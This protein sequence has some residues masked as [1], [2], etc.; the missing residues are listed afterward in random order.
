MRRQLWNTLIAVAVA[1]TLACNT[2]KAPAEAA[3]KAAEDAVNAARAQ[4]EKM[5]PDDFKS[6]SDDLAA[7]K[8]LFAKGDYKGALAAAQ[9]IPAKVS[10]VVAKANAKKEELAKAWAAASGD[11][12]KA[13]GDLKARL[14][15]LASTKKLPKGLTADTVKAA[16]D[17]LAAAGQSLSDATAAATAGNVS[18]AIAKAGDAKTK[19]GAALASVTVA[20]ATAA[21]K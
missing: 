6:L 5:A 9:A 15:E 16:G 19:A 1:V 11:A 14:D 8:D 21:K 20:P 18:E 13:V 7:A 4:V 2:A 10:E 17:T 12:T 3:L